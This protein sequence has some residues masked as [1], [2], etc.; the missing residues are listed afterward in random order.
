MTYEYQRHQRPAQVGLRLQSVGECLK[1]A[2]TA[3]AVL[4]MDTGIGVVNVSE[5]TK[6]CIKTLTTLANG[7]RVTHLQLV[8]G[9]INLK[10]RPFSNPKS[11]LE[12]HSPVGIT[13]VRGTEFGVSVQ[14]NGQTGVA[15]LSGRVSAAAQQTSVLVG[16]NLQT[17]IIPYEPPLPPQPLNNHPGLQ[18]DLVMP[19]DRQVQVKGR[20]DPTHILLVRGEL[21][22]ISRSGTFDL[23]VPMIREIPLTFTVITPLGNQKV[24]ALPPLL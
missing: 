15:T 1:T 2:P 20:I 21:Q 17:L 7:G 19:M 10:V 11:R 22:A 16:A 5:N 8:Q 23:I 9:Q 13:G 18:L 6:L 3:K 4:A 14:P 12:I 24:Y